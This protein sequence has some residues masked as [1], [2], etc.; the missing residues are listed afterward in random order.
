MKGRD[1]MYERSAIVLEKY[2]EKIFEFNKIYNL[3]TNLS[4]YKNLLEEIA[5]YQIIV[6]RES[7]II[8]EFDENAKKIEN[9]QKKQNKI[10]EDNQK[11]EKMRNTLFK[12]LGEDADN[13]ENKFL[14]IETT[15]EQNN[16][17]LIK[18][19]QEF[20][21]CL[22]DFSARQKERNKCEKEKRVA[23]RNH[24]AFINKIKE[25]FQQIDIKNVIK[26]KEFITAEKDPIKKQ[27]TEAMIKN[28]KNEKIGFN[29]DV[30]KIAIKARIN[31]AEKEAEI[32][33]LIYDKMKKLLAEIETDNI[34]INKYQKTL[35]DVSVKLA[36]LEAEKEYIVGFLDYERMTVIAGVRTHKKKMEEACQN[37]ELDMIQIH[38]L[39]ELI[40]R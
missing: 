3:N 27:I 23:E 6:E 12:D 5:N 38:N 30:L 1:N 13:L 24:I 28:G 31:I 10:Y 4:N 37:F 19:R 20:I 26:I 16:E 2:I 36:F 25:E 18:L 22:T 17:E 11:N 21:E 39:Y 9:I 32:Y 40:L 33:T 35:R 15:I 34:K 8:Q 7:K 29:Q 14:K